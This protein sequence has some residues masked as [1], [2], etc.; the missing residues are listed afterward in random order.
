MQALLNNI[1]TFLGNALNNPYVNAALTIFLVLYAGLAAPNL[2]PFIAGLFDCA[3]FKFLVL[4]LILAVRNYSTTVALLG[5]LGFILSIQT[6]GRYRLFQKAS[7]LLGR[8]SGVEG[9]DVDAPAAE[10]TAPETAEVA[11]EVAEAAGC[12]AG[13]SCQDLA[14]GEPLGSDAVLPP[15][16]AE[17][18][19]SGVCGCDWQ[20]PQGL[21]EPSGFE[22]PECGAKLDDEL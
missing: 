10:A 13:T 15:Q 4:F 6:L 5:A 16:D 20:G 9:A 8:A 17:E 14:C 18:A 21:K 12:G 3:L 22:G 1:D 7:A 11:A 2:P 19:V